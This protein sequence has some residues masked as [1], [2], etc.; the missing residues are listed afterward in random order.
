MRK[1][2]NKGFESELDKH[3]LSSPIKTG[4]A[5]FKY[6]LKRQ[7]QKKPKLSM[8]R[9]SDRTDLCMH[10]FAWCLTQLC[11]YHQSHQRKLRSARLAAIVFG[12]T[13]QLGTE[14][15]KYVVSSTLS[16]FR[17]RIRLRD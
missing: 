11:A 1:K 6:S 8:R 5:M 2:L 7:Q 9:A 13:Q 17:R 3:N 10:A 15:S 4:N 16:E 12:L 14:F